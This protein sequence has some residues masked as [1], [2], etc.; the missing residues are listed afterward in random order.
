[1]DSSRTSNDSSAPYDSS[2]GATPGDYFRV[3][4]E[5]KLVILI[6]T[7]VAI[8]V[9]AIYSW[10][11]TPMYRATTEV[12]RQTAAL[13]Q[14]LFGTSVF[15]FKDEARELQNGASLIKINEVAK[16][17]KDDLKSQLSVD[18]LLRMVAVTTSTANDLIHISATSSKPVEAADV[19]NSFSHQFILYRQQ[20]DRSIL[21]AADKQVV[22]ELA[23]MNATEL[24]SERGTTLTQKHEELGILEAMQTGGFEIVQEAGAPASPVSPK[25]VRN[26]GFALVGGLVLG[27]LLAFLLDYVDRRIKND[28]AMEKAFNLP[29]LASV[30]TIGHK[31]RSRHPDHLEK[32]VGFSDESSA[33][34]ESFRTLRSNLRF[35]QGDKRTQTLLITSGLPQ[36]GKTVTAVN[37]A[38][39]LALSGVRVVLLEGDL[40]RPML[41][42]YLKLSN[43]VG[44]SSVLASTV[45]FEDALQV[46]KLADFAAPDSEYTTSELA[47]ST[48]KAGLLCLTSGPLP[49]N[50]G[51]LLSSAR[52]RDLIAWAASL[53]ECVIID[54]PPLLVVSDALNIATNCD[55]VIIATRVKGTTW[56]EAR[57][58]RNMIT[59]SGCRALGVVANGTPHKQ[60]DYYRG[61]YE[62]YYPN[63]RTS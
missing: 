53:A 2:R 54:T 11:Q 55:G 7:I 30:P 43:R 9:I 42:D 14:T 38:L 60:G 15:Q 10:V 57:D 12:L 40:R 48:M 46:V 28:E 6:V 4:R 26:V 63:A 13:D 44:V 1:M 22:A 32:L 41:H 58:V 17:V 5:R 35:Y 47:K 45:T 34:F 16:M 59:R 8:G 36:E 39:S 37:L 25:P 21:A 29:V 19:A 31:W 20:A 33:F 52:M 18:D 27:I 51:E 3:I 24:A 50:P 61:R 62:G 23:T 49:P 56:P